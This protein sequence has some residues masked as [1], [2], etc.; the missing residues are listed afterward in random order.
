[1]TIAIVLAAGKGTRMRSHLPKVAHKLAGVPLI[2][3]VHAAIVELGDCAPLYVLGHQHEVVRA[4]LPADVVTVLQEEQRGTGH[5]VQTA[6]GSLPETSDEVFILYGDMPLLT[7]QTL[8]DLRAHHRRSGARL[9]LL[10]A[11]VAEPDGYGRIIRDAAG[12]PREIIEQKWLTPPQREIREI[13]T[14]LYVADSVWLRRAIQ[15]MPKHPDGEMYLTDLAEAAAKDGELAVLTGGAA[16]E[17]LGI[18]DRAA[19]AAAERLMRRRIAGRLMLSGVTLIDPETAYIAADAAVGMDTVIEPNVWIDHGVTIGERCRI[20]TNSRI[21]ASAIGDD[22]KIDCSVIEYAELESHVSVG[23]FSHL[24][25]GA[26][27]GEGVH[28]GNFAEIKNSTLD[29]GTKVPHFSYLGDAVV[30][31]R[32]NVGAGTV[33]ANYDGTAKQRTTIG[34]QAFVGVGSLLRAPVTI[35]PHSTTGA[36]S[37]VLADVPAGATVAGVPAH[38]IARRVHPSQSNP[39]STPEVE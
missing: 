11:E 27:L 6:L 30:G 16:D 31:K 23:P 38:P 3:H 1:M 14:G 7:T 34:D 12:E 10:S 25:P 5:A 9:T 39:P 20:G 32:V 33:T 17:V 13:N 28:V 19:L 21:V 22:C 8:A 29:A 18:N 2:L 26:A 37:V 15:S 35:G 36:G 24:R 4:M